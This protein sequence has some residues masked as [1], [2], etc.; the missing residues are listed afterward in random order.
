MVIDIGAHAGYHTLRFARLVG[1]Q[2]K[3][4]AFEPSPKTFQVLKRN[5]MRKGLTNVVLEQK[6]VTDYNGECQ[7]YVFSGQGSKWSASDSLVAYSPDQVAITVPCIA[8]DN[9]FRREDILPD[10]KNKC[11]GSQASCVKRDAGFIVSNQED[12]TN[13]GVLPTPH[14]SL[15]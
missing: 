1:P 2:G 4:F 14:C 9:Y 10:L 3:V 7:F 12:R 13:Y 5:V 6:V 8:L 15:G 11:R